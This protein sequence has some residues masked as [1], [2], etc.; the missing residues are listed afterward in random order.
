MQ[1]P[2]ERWRC[3]W[4][5]ARVHRRPSCR[6]SSLAF[7]TSSLRPLY[8]LGF[9]WRS[10]HRCGVYFN[11]LCVATKLSTTPDASKLGEVG[12]SSLPVFN[13]CPL[14]ALPLWLKI[15]A[16]SIFSLTLNLPCASLTHYLPRMH[17]RHAAGKLIMASMWSPY[18][19][20][21]MRALAPSFRKDS[22]LVTSVPIISLAFRKRST[23]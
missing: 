12:I 11:L 9:F 23:F 4:G 20:S 13:I 7:G 5:E 21:S 2:F 16:I 3:S 1:F 17:R 18:E 14:G 8:P 19:K 15:S 22:P 10:L 6:P